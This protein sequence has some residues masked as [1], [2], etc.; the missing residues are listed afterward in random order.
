MNFAWKLM[1]PMCLLNLLVVAAWRF[2]GEGLLRWVICS[3]ILIAAYAG[4]GLNELRRKQI[5]PRRY[6]Y[7]E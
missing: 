6:R 4:M 3:A 7:A 5:G 1:L 2:L